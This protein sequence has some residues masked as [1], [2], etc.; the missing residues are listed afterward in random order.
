MTTTQRTAY[1]TSHTDLAEAR[2]AQAAG[3]PWRGFWRITSIRRVRAVWPLPE[4]LHEITGEAIPGQ[5]TAA[6]C[7]QQPD[8]H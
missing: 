2:I 5:T 8:G 1:T 6:G 3:I 7:D 4:G